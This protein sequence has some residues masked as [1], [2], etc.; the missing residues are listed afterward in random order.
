[1]VATQLPLVT[2]RLLRGLDG[3]KR[4]SSLTLHEQKQLP[5]SS[6]Y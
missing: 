2:A 5:G 1:M 6:G 3:P 4:T